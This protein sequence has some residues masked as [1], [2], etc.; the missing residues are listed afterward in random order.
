MFINIHQCQ[1]L[2]NHYHWIRPKFLLIQ[3]AVPKHSSVGPLHWDSPSTAANSPTWV[4]RRHEPIKPKPNHQLNE[5]PMDPSA[6]LHP[7]HLAAKNQ[8]RQSPGSQLPVSEPWLWLPVSWRSFFFWP[9]PGA[10][11]RLVPW[12]SPCP[13]LPPQFDHQC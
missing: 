5:P 7:W 1:P 10:L 12:V 13:D 6:F 8:H 3:S 2:V 11:K 4:S 9:R